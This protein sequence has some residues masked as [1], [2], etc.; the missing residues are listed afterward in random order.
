[1]ASEQYL[2]VY[3]HSLS[4]ILAKAVFEGLGYEVKFKEIEWTAKY[5]DL[6]SGA[7]YTI[8]LEIEGFHELTGAISGSFETK[9]LTT[10]SDFTAKT[11]SEDG[12]VILSFSVDGPESHNWNVTY[13]TE[14]EE[15]GEF[16]YYNIEDDEEY[17]FVAD[18]FIERLQ[19]LYEI[20]EK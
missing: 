2:E 12:S 20:D 15:D 7:I 16:Y 8:S 11:G 1:M 13:S 17:E 5:T 19:D 3:R 9:E 10:I 4:H 14:G 18:A 6:N